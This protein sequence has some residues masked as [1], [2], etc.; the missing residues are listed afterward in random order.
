M[1]TPQSGVCS[2]NNSLSSQLKRTFYYPNLPGHKLT[3]TAEKITEQH[4]DYARLSVEKL[5]R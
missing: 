4:I 1:P 3:L 5:A 2:G